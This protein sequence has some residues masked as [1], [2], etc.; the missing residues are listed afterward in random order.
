MRYHRATRL[1]AVPAAAALLLS[2]GCTASHR[3]PPPGATTT[4][5]IAWLDSPATPPTPPGP[6]S[7]PTARPCTA[8]D[9]PASTTFEPTQGLSQAESYLIHLPN[10]ATTPCTLPSDASLLYTDQHGRTQLLP[11]D[12]AAI[13]NPGGPAGPATIG[14]GQTATLTVVISHA[15]TGDPV[16]YQ[17]ISVEQSGK[18]I[19]V[20]GLSLGGTCSTV[21]IGRWQ[22]PQPPPSPPPSLRYGALSAQLDP[23][24][25]SHPGATLDYVLTL[26]NPTT[27]PVPLDPCPVYQETIYKQQATYRL[28]CTAG[29]IPAGGSLRFSM[30][31][32][33]PPYTPAGHTRITWTILEADGPSTTA[34]API[35]VI[36]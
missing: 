23:P 35:D 31:I 1:L 27:H 22:P 24:A 16:S 6:P 15:C 34:S 25:S 17:G 9:L 7:V 4:G 32:T 36:E 28:N 20:P 14:P 2:S 19:P 13:A 3:N 8:T 30:R 18:R 21:H 5:L 12:H 10:T 29:S 11:T 33:V 26:A